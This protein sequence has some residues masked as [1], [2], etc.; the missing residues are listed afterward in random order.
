ME[1][2][3]GGN[4]KELCMIFCLFVCLFSP[5][6]GDSGLIKKLFLLGKQEE[7]KQIYVVRMK[8]CLTPPVSTIEFNIFAAW[9]NIV[10]QASL[11]LC[12]PAC[13][14]LPSNKHSV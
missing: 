1:K 2:H 12:F 6:L 7:R 9:P 4:G 10:S 5:F 14:S 8:V 13:T 3:Q 11:T